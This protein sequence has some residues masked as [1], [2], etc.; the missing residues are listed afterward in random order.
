[1]SY[2]ENANENKNG[3]TYNYITSQN[4][5]PQLTNVNEDQ[6]NQDSRSVLGGRGMQNDIT[7]FKGSLAVS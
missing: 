5:E 7:T 4:P 6:R 2:R 3:I 1:M